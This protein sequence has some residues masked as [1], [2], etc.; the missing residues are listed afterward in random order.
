M[1]GKSLIVATRLRRAGFRQP[2][3]AVRGPDAPIADP[4]RRFPKADDGNLPICA[5]VLREEERILYEGDV[6]PASEREPLADPVRQ[7]RIHD[8]EPR[9]GVDEIAAVEEL[10]ASTGRCPRTQIQ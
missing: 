7:E 5:H 9:R 10:L 8:L 3:P 6:P 4:A 2:V 1:V